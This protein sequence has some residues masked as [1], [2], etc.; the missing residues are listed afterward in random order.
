MYRNDGSSLFLISATI[1]NACASGASSGNPWRV[2][3]LRANAGKGENPRKA[4]SPEG[5]AITYSRNASRW[6]QIVS[7]VMMRAGWGY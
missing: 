7:R 2:I 4:L 3:P 6:D 5:R 1:F